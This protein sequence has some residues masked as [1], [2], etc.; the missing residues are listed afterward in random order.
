[1]LG[2]F[3][4]CNETEMLHRSNPVEEA[5]MLPS[6]VGCSELVALGMDH[7]NTAD[8]LLDVG[9]ACVLVSMRRIPLVAVE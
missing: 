3:G 2:G 4:C 1:M 8:I 6:N 5:E 7:E 9:M